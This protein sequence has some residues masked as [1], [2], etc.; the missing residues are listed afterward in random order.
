MKESEKPLILF[1]SYTA[2]W[3]GPTN[4]LSL[5]LRG[6]RENFRVAVLHAGDGPFAEELTRRGIP[7]WGRDRLDKWSIP[8][9][10][11]L[12]RREDI[13]LVYANSMDGTARNAFIASMLTGRPF[14]CHARSMGWNVPWHKVAYLRWADAVI[15]VSRACAEPL[16]RFVPSEHLHVVHNGISASFGREASAETRNEIRRELD[17]PTE[18]RLVLSVAHVN[19]RKSQ[20]D[21]VDALA[22][23]ADRDPELHLCLV[24]SLTKDPGYVDRVR[25]RISEH[26]LGNRIRVLGFRRDIA[27]LMKASDIFLH[28]ALADPHPRAV[29]EAMTCELPVIAYAVDGVAETVVDGETGRLVSPGDEEALARALWEL[30]DSPASRSRMGTAGRRLVERRFDDGATTSGVKRIL[31]EVLGHGT[32]KD[33]EKTSIPAVVD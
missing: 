30:V 21:A 8:W 25:R 29:L 31:C 28:T 3:L 12:F 19:P 10:A 17:V 1:I 18:A 5:L 16:D 14:V 4:S 23:L 11:R 9:V 15:A 6:L 13:D 32:C 22:I 20:L 7:H 26:G 33:L 2:D 24:G 27:S